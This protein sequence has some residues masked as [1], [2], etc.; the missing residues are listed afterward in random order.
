MLAVVTKFLKNNQ[1]YSLRDGNCEDFSEQMTW[2]ILITNLIHCEFEYMNYRKSQFYKQTRL[3]KYRGVSWRYS[4]ELFT[5]R[6]LGGHTKLGQTRLFLL[7]QF[8]VCLVFSALFWKFAPSWESV[9]A[10]LPPRW[11]EATA[12]IPL[13][14]LVAMI[15]GLKWRF[16][17]LANCGAWLLSANWKSSNSIIIFTLALVI[18]VLWKLWGVRK[19]LFDL[20]GMWEIKALM[21]S[22]F[23][24]LLVSAVLVWT[25]TAAS[26]TLIVV[27][28]LT[29]SISVL[30]IVWPT[31]DGG[32]SSFHFRPSISYAE[33]LR[34]ISE[35]GWQEIDLQQ[36]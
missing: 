29:L 1:N 33:M 4:S 3:I 25:D 22:Q 8:A 28:S 35:M 21:F 6:Y 30:F 5:S 27:P 32:G 2:D 16:F 23:A 10:V 31:S 7:A 24:A 9:V 13:V 18:S 20:W 15:Y 11:K 17:I 12:V 26:Q 14:V 36:E 19:F 34:R